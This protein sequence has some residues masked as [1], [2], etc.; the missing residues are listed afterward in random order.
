[1]L[2]KHIC[3]GF[4]LPQLDKLACENLEV[5]DGGPKKIVFDEPENILGD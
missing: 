5:G 3:C 4:L 2:D 1:M